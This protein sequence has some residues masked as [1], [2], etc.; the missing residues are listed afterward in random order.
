MRTSRFASRPFVDALCFV[1]IYT[2]V[3]SLCAPFIIRRVEA[4]LRSSG[5]NKSRPAPASNQVNR[6][7]GKRDGELLVRF[8]AGV[9]ETEKTTIVAAKGAQRAKRLRGQ[10]RLEQLQLTAGQLPEALAAELRLNPAVEMAEPNYLISSAELV[11]DDPRFAEQWAL[12]NT[13]TNGGQTGADI[14]A[15]MAWETTTGT[16]STVI[17]VI[18]SGV[19]FTHPDL[20]HNQWVNKNERAN[21]QDDD[22]NGYVDDTQGWDWIAGSGQTKDEQGH[23]TA[24]AGIIAAEGNNHT[25]ITGVM[26]KAS[27]MSLRV[28]DQTGTGDVASAIEAIDYAIARGAQVIN[29]SWGT[30]EPSQALRDAIVRA[31]RR[32]VVVVCAAGNAGRDLDSTPHYPASFNIPDLIAVAATDQLDQ[33]ASWSNWSATHATLAAPGTD[34]LTTQ[35]A[36]TIRRS[37]AHRRQPRWSPVS[38][39]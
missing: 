13:G 25:G 37:A 1:L 16:S 26:W 5:A 19:D 34:L 17:A 27:L 12:R 10:S 23:G 8:R 7:G 38:L 36:V 3:V 35:K 30:D 29:L 32:G 11:P 22:R 33:L 15:A 6:K 39:G 9:S 21:A 2:I 4:S 24:V 14:A 31:T 20:Q 28:L 18:D